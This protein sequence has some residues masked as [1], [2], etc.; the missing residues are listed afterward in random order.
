M[1]GTCAQSSRRQL[2]QLNAEV[3]GNG[4]RKA[5]AAPTSRRED[6]LGRLTLPR[7]RVRPPHRRVA[8]AA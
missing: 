7:G 2:C 3:G 1:S 4:P 6:A 8:P 5:L